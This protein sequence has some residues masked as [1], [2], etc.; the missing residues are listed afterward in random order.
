[1]H[2]VYIAYNV[3]YTLYMEYINVSVMHRYKFG[4]NCGN[5]NVNPIFYP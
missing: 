1:M 5:L 4:N 3:M 2:K